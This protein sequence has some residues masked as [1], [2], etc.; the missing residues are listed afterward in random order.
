MSEV[1]VYVFPGMMFMFLFF[2]TQNAMMEI[3]IENENHT[4]HRILSTT[5]SVRQFL[6]SKLLR[7]FLLGAIVMMTALVFTSIVFGMKLG[8]L[9]YMISVILACTFSVTGI[10]A[11]V[12]G[13]S[14]TKDQANAL[15]TMIIMFCAMMGGS[16]VNYEALP[17]FMK[18]I[19]RFT[20]NRWGILAIQNVIRS[21]GFS[22]LITPMSI[23]FLF[24][25]IGCTIGLLL[26]IRK[27]K[28][29]G[30]K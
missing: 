10:L 17:Q 7:C 25:A 27:F 9:I 5:V 23:L 2:I 29:F 11:V 28:T 22:E 24:G 12:Y 18:L 3:I 14:K 19:G 1:I 13:I 16:M 26:F 20:P 4:L 6:I 15:G 30:T 21:R 8:N